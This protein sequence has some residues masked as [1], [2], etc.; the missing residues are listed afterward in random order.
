[1]RAFGLRGIEDDR[2]RRPVLGAVVAENRGS[3]IEHE[4][5]TLF[6]RHDLLL[7]GRPGNGYDVIA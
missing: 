1:M 2:H 6:V 4:P 7:S 5:P 3:V